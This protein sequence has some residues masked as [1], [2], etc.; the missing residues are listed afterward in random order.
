MPLHSNHFALRIFLSLSLILCLP[1]S[2]ARTQD[3]D[4]EVVANLAAGRIFV[5]IAKDGI[6]VGALDGAAE[7]GSHPPAFLPL[8]SKRIAVLLGAV[9]W[10]TPTGG[11]D[12]VRMDRELQQLIGKI[13]GQRPGPGKLIPTDPD[14]IQQIGLALLEPLRAAAG[15]L[16]R[17]IQLPADSPVLELVLIGYIEGYGPEVWKISYHLVQEPLRGSYFRTRVV[18]PSYAQLYP[19]EKDQ[20]RTLMEIAYPPEDA[21]PTLA[22]QLNSD[23]RFQRI[24]IADEQMVRASLALKNG[25]SHKVVAADE[26]ALLRALLGVLGGP[27]ARPV[28]GVID[29]ERGLDWTLPPAV[30]FQTADEAKP[31][32][33]GAPTM[34]KPPQNN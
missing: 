17:P 7:P 25:E 16:H 2:A 19:P 11:G 26:A 13:G 10:T 32:P 22:S 5:V 34:R 1:W 9:E 20:P 3:Q 15:R 21:P 14:D 4:T 24:R 27:D 12:P 6:V 31:R 33:P 18:Y 30:P 8:G 23:P 29:F 28:L